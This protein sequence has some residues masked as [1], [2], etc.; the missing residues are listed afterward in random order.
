MLLGMQWQR[1]KIPSL[2]QDSNPDHP[3]HNLVTIPTELSQLL[4]KIYNKEKVF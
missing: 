1:E 3:A 4:D 2:C